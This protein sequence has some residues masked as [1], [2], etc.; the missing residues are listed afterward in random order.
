MY[1]RELIPAYM[2]LIEQGGLFG[3]G[4]VNYPT[5]HGQRSIDNEYLLLGVTQ[6]YWGFSFF[7]LII[8]EAV[9]TLILSL[10]TMRARQD[11]TFVFMLLGILAGIC[12]SISTVFIAYQVQQLLFLLA[13]WSCSLRPTKHEVEE[14]SKPAPIHARFE[15]V[16]S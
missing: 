2:P 14:Q 1:R 7:L 9:V 4:I 11:R 15:K 6:G 16:Y 12:L 13:G 5:R 3:W 10:R 8:G